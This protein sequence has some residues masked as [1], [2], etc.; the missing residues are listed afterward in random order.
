MALLSCTKC[1]HPVSSGADICPQCGQLMPIEKLRFVV[2][3]I[4][5]TLVL[6]NLLYL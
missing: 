6:M 5:A 1:D 2:K 3:L 4:L